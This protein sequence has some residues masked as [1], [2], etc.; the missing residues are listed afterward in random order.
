M[1]AESP[2]IGSVKIQRTSSA[3]NLAGIPAGLSVLSLYNAAVHLP[4]V[5][6][7]AE[8]SVSLTVIVFS[9]L[10][11]AIPVFCASMAENE[12][13]RHTD[14]SD[15]VYL[16]F[17]CLYKKCYPLRV[18]VISYGYIFPKPENKVLNSVQVQDELSAD[19]R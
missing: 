14:C 1:E 6:L 17:F 8:A 4:A 7:S 10:L 13:D 11:S 9:F 12:A 3:V 2:E 18:H 5:L 15:T 16:L 19:L